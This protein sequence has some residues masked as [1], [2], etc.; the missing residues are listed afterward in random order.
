MA[1][2]FLKFRKGYV[3]IK[4]EGANPVGFLDE[5]LKRGISLWNVQWMGSERLRCQV[6]LQDFWS[7]REVVK[8]NGNRFH[9]EAKKGWPFILAGWRKRPLLLGGAVAFVLL[10]YLLSSFVWSVEIST[11]QPLRYV[12]QGEILTEAANLG[13]E[14]G[15]FKPWLDLRAGERE[16]AKRYPQLAW[17]GMEI[18]GTKLTIHV[19]EKVFFEDQ[20]PQRPGSVI[21]SRAG[22]VEEIL[23]LN[24]QALVK[25]GE[26]VSEGQT[27]ISGIIRRQAEEGE[28]PLPPN[29]VIAQG[30]VRART[31]HTKT[32]TLPLKEE[33][34]RPAGEKE[35]LVKVRAGEKVWQL[36]GP[37][38][39]PGQYHLEVKTIKLPA[40]RNHE[41][42]VEV[43]LETYHK[44]ERKIVTRTP[45]GA[46]E[47]AFRLA[48][49]ELEGTLDQKAKLLKRYVDPS[50]EGETVKVK[51]IWE[52]SEDIGQFQPL[53]GMA[54]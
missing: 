32:V 4:V 16:L 47:E 3:T 53:P 30:L 42:P 51:V 21:A 25:P 11:V 10:L 12:E 35:T 31:W 43:V 24:G 40:W 8:A 27:L 38:E 52:C 6:L 15:S 2:S 44:L 41:A 29:Y 34:L 20:E 5:S 18:K 33:Q 23:V 36:W 17:V 28:E 14:K 19:V 49:R 46:V 22:L 9:V 1:N 39:I 50:R 37:Q 45:Q 13:F 7:L 54:E 48:E 26:T